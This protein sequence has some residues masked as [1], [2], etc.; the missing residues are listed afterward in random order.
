MTQDEIRRKELSDFLRTR[1]ARVAPADVG[2]LATPRRRTPGLRRDEVAQLAGISVSWYS[3]LEQKRPIRVSPRIL[4]NL[5]RVL[6]L[7][8]AER[9]QLFQLAL[10]QPAI[11]ATGAREEVSPGIQRMLDQM[12]SIAAFIRGRRWDILAWNRAARAFFFDFEKVA[13]DERNLVWLIFT[14]PALRSLMGVDWQTR[15]QDVLARFRL[16]YGRYAGDTHFLQ[17]VERLNTVSPEFARW[18]PR[19]DVLPQSEGRK[20]YNHEVAGLIVAEHFTFSMTDNPELR[21]T[22]FS[23]VDN[24]SSAGMR[25]AVAAH[26]NK[27]STRDHRHNGRATSNS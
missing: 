22:V 12:D 5:A 24:K 10:R 20:Q 21:I 8:P 11:E 18:W 26:W 25:Q 19:F 6:H 14:R 4:E 9:I 15:A 3:W 7:N 2:L 16:D 13:P 27:S 17:L 23:P 1:R